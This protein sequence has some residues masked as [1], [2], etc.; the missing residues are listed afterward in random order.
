MIRHPH[1]Q[2]YPKHGCCYVKSVIVNAAHKT[3]FACSKGSFFSVQILM[4]TE[5]YIV[6]VTAVLFFEIK[7][8]YKL[9]TCSTKYKHSSLHL[10]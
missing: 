1:T 3:S 6:L 10:N 9:W 2:K 5:N 4:K 7:S 8:K